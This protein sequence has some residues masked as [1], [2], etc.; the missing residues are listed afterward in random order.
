MS[1]INRPLDKKQ[2]LPSRTMIKELRDAVVCSFVAL[3][4]LLVLGWL[5]G[6][7]I[8]MIVLNPA[9][10]VGMIVACS[11][12]CWM[13]AIVYRMTYKRWWP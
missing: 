13:I 10:W 5:S 1:D 8:S 6:K 9:V 7:S 4:I 11:V 2:W 12:N 3:L